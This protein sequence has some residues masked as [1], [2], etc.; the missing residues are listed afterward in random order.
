MDLACPP[1]QDSEIVLLRDRYKYC[2][3]Y[4]WAT[5]AMQRDDRLPIPVSWWRSVC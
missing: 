4:V 3:D 1:G 5:S 2:T